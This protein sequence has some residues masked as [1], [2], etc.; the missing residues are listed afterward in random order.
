MNIRSTG[1]AKFPAEGKLRPVLFFSTVIQEGYK[2]IRNRQRAKSKTVATNIKTDA[3][4]AV[5]KASL[6]INKNNIS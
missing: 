5:N 2:Y 4:G 3:P 1:N 6:D